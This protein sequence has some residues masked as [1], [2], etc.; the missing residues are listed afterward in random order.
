MKY[1]D[2][3]HFEPI[4]SVKQLR[5]GGAE[6]QAAEDV[7]S[8][9]IS[10]SMR[11][12]LTGIVIPQ[13]RFDN[14]DVDH[15]GLLLVATYG[16]G[17][18]HL[19]STIAGVAEH[20]KLAG[21]L[22]DTVTAE[23]AAS[24]AGRFKVV[25]I[26]IG[27]VRMGLRDIL[28]RELS[29][30]LAA[31]GVTYEFP[32][33]DQVANNKDS[34]AEMMAAFESVYPE[35]GLLVVI[36]ELLD[37]LR[38]RKDSEL[39]LDLGFLR[40]MGEFCQS[41]RFRVIV[42]VQEMLWD[43]PRFAIAQDEIRRVRERYQ[44]FR[45]SRDDVAYVVRERLLKKDESQ[46]A[47]IR[48]HLTKFAPGFES[49]GSQLEDFVELFPVHPAYLRTFENLTIVEKR[50]I[51]ETL[52]AQM[53]MRL[54][55]EVPSD[56]PGLICFDEYRADLD[57]DPSNRVIPE[58]KE[59]LERA[60]VLRERVSRG[61]RNKADVAPALRIVDALTVHRLT[62]DDIHAP[63]GLTPEEL[64]D[65]LCLLPPDT[66]ELD[67]AFIASTIETIVDEIR[68]AVSGQFL[69]VND[70]NGQV[71]IDLNKTVDYEQQI[72]ERA[73]TLDEE[74]L[75]NA[76]YNA[77][78][79]VLEVND[80]PYVSGYRIWQY[81]LSWSSHKVSRLGYLFM[82][83]PNERS[84]AQPPRDFYVYFLQPYSRHDFVDERR[85][86]EVF[87]RL[88]NPDETF[89]TALRRYAGAAQKAVE[90]TAQHR[91]AFEQ[92]RDSYLG[93]MVEWL[94]THMATNMSVTYA[95][96]E[97]LFGQW[98]AAAAGTR[99][100]VKDQ[101]DSIAAHLLE[102]HFDRRYP[103][104]P[105][106]SQEITRANLETTVQAALQMIAGRRDTALGRIALEGLQLLDINGT[107]TADGPYAQHLLAQLEAAAGKAVNR[108]ALLV[109]REL[110]V[111]TWG[112]WHL[113]PAWLVVVA[114]ALVYLG[115][116]EVGMPSGT[117]GAIQLERLA[118][119]PLAE[120]EQISHIVVPAGLDVAKLRRVA[121][122]VGVTPGAITENLESDVVVQ[123]ISKAEALHTTASDGKNLVLE[124][125]RLW[126]E[127][128]FDDPVQR[129]G[130]IDA[131]ITAL[132]DIKGRNTAGKMRNLAL[133]ESQLAEAEQ[134]LKELG[135]VNDL[136]LIYDRLG[137]VTDY[138]SSA[139]SV[140]GD[141]DPFIVEA[142]AIRSRLRELIR[143]NQIDKTAAAA[144]NAEAEQLRARYRKLAVDYHTHDRLDGAGDAAKQALVASGTWRDLRM[145]SQVSIIP[146]GKFASLESKL[147]SVGTCKTFKP[148]YFER[149]YICPDCKYRPAKTDG[150]TA[151]AVITNIEKAAEQLR[152]EFLDA[153]A[154]SLAEP[155]LADGIPFLPEG[156]Q[157]TIR[158]FISSHRLPAGVTEEFVTAANQLL[159]RFEIVRVDRDG[160]WTRV[161]AGATSLT[162]EELAHRFAR[163][164]DDEVIKGH[165][166]GRVRIVPAEGG[167]A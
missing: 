129:A 125:P 96:E 66:P 5:A 127:E 152:E 94:R 100:T 13:L 61:L 105:K 110:G 126:G 107:I 3:V 24:I 25:R 147:A 74:A 120:L 67:P 88:V 36:D 82:G 59:V 28:A 23:H 135:R 69:S 57:A 148:E 80:D 138:L 78:E 50:R 76:Y 11:D 45:I 37:Y 165:D 155:E 4:E 53:K 109:E 26:E 137:P 106:F 33:L 55:N 119:S 60:R 7:R 128:L 47:L 84:T 142:D 31:M 83:A 143:A 162:P 139:A 90:T 10:E 12:V 118:N 134:G 56:S 49:M 166:R 93:D 154:D 114:A 30:G 8:Y 89:T 38:T 71:Y 159:Q 40:E 77:L 54:A 1:G 99:R 104:Y 153:L 64:R 111:W 103:G 92:R 117:I 95:G 101:V 122:L 2:L 72:E 97:K 145:L 161:M 29:R 41:S 167:S 14:P 98:L 102:T 115:R 6:D 70:T 157:V 65:D 160:M 163:W 121:K 39:I 85:P 136:K 19:M 164:L 51:L 20:A 86:D 141:D 73:A 68:L 43:N 124:N 150:P 130:R 52:S 81:E 112:S 149:D 156:V 46:R 75:D 15:K 63:I 91:A 79:R 44:Q 22:T 34:L 42:G 133:N 16:T 62:T 144:V 9:V 116:A 32:P 146:A 48:N 123:L 35:L 151:R 113:E 87:L 21:L 58:I 140:L 158:E 27:A 18:T 108:N 131:L 17:K 132:A